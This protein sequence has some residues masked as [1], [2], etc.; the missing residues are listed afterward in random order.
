MDEIKWPLQYSRLETGKS[1]PIGDW[2]GIFIRGD[3]ALGYAIGLR[4]FLE[5]VEKMKENGLL[6]SIFGLMHLQALVGLL[7]DANQHNGIES[8]KIAKI[9]NSL[10]IMDVLQESEIPDAWLIK[11]FENMASA[12]ADDFLFIEKIRIDIVVKNLEHI[13]K[14][15]GAEK[16]EFQSR[17]EW[18]KALSNRMRS[19]FLFLR[20]G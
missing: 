11:R 9:D 18:M 12:T 15:D 19:D 7:S 20:K 6:T 14:M 13:A 1:E 3:E 17:F 2:S 4:D 10:M 8:Q 16:K 5:E